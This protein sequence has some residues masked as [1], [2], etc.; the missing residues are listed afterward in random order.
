MA[1]APAIAQCASFGTITLT[2]TCRYLSISISPDTYSFGIVDTNSTVTS[3]GSNTVKN[4]GNAPETFWLSGANTAN[5]TLQNAPGINQ[6]SLYAIFNSTQPAN[7]DFGS[8][9]NL[10]TSS[11]AS[12]VSRFAGGENGVSVSNNSERHCWFRFAAPTALTA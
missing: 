12:T 3:T 7:N 8:D 9:D 6:F 10:T 11:Q 5:W 4:D 2:V 1:L